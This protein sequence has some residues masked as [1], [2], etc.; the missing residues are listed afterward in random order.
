VKP[1][2][3]ENVAVM[4]CDIVGFTRYCDTREPEEVLGHLQ[5]LCVAFEDAAQRH[6]LQKIKT[7]GDGFMAVGGLLVPIDAPARSCVQCASDMHAAVAALGIGW[8]VRIGVHVGPVVAGVLGKRQFQYD[9]WGDT[10]NTASRVEAYGR[11]GATTLSRS[12]WDALAPFAP[13]GLA[14]GKVELKGKGEVELFE[15]QSCG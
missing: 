13:Q 11:N 14:L 3:F 12:A 1:R 15:F 2:R 10:V 4:F 5:K 7:I 9:L 8:R 6:Q